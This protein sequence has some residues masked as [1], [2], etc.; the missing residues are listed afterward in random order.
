MIRL[1]LAVKSTANFGIGAT[2][3][4][5]SVSTLTCGTAAFPLLPF[6]GAITGEPAGA[7]RAALGNGGGFAPLIGGPETSDGAVTSLGRNLI[8]RTSAV[9]GGSGEMGTLVAGSLGTKPLSKTVLG[10]I[11]DAG[12]L[13]AGPLGI[14]LSEELGSNEV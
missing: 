6:G 10:G 4:T 5:S 7:C 12:S 13:G 8:T 1:L 11:G 3:S 2:T 9:L 14:Q